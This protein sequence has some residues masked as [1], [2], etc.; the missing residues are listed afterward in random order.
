MQLNAE[1]HGDDDA[2][3]GSVA[4]GEGAFVIDGAGSD[5]FTFGEILWINTGT[6]KPPEEERAWFDFVSDDGGGE[7]VTFLKACC[8]GVQFCFGRLQVEH[9]ASRVRILSLLAKE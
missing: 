4:E 6:L 9:R 3:K 1:G 8:R 2:R 5:E 7:D